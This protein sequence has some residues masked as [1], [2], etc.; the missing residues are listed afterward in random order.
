MGRL[1]GSKRLGNGSLLVIRIYT[2]F[3]VVRDQVFYTALEVVAAGSS[4]N[5]GECRSVPRGV[6]VAFDQAT[7]E[8]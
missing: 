5:T 8:V 4:R 1:K 2:A 7:P 6:G 3:V